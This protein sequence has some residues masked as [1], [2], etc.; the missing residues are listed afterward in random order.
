MGV[1]VYRNRTTIF[2]TGELR[3]N[4]TSQ[5][6]NVGVTL[7]GLFIVC[8]L[9]H[10]FLF[11]LVQYIGLSFGSTSPP[12]PSDSA[13]LYVNNTGAHAVYKPPLFDVGI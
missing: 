5:E 2:C 8:N 10:E 3:F 11:V 7:L 9:L 4:S 1:F 13:A 12:P 6:K